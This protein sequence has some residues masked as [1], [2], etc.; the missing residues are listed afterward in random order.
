MLNLL[1]V[2]FRDFFFSCKASFLS[3]LAA[4][5]TRFLLIILIVMPISIFALLDLLSSANFDS[6]RLGT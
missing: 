1:N 3:L 4:S 2:A 6:S 5:L